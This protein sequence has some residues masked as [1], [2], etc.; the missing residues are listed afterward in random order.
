MMK[1]ISTTV[2]LLIIITTNTTTATI[3]RQYQLVYQLWVFVFLK[4]L[5]S[6]WLG[7]DISEVL[8]VALINVDVRRERELYIA[9]NNA[10]HLL[11]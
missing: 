1:T 3:I 6:F 9:R 7:V 4:R 11:L 5:L 2:L 10:M 8:T